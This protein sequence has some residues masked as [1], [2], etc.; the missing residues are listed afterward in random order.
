MALQTLGELHKK[1]FIH[2][3]KQ[4]NIDP[5]SGSEKRINYATQFK[6]LGEVVTIYDSGKIVIAT[7][8]LNKVREY[9]IEVKKR[10]ELKCVC[11][12]ENCKHIQ[13]AAAPI[14]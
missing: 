6:V 2:Y 10:V 13:A 8:D 7:R 4:D 1:Q 9:L 14:W 12:M 11:G 3:L 5:E